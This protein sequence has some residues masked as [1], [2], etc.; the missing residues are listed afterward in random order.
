MVMCF[1]SYVMF[2]S[3]LAQLSVGMFFPSMSTF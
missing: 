1:V 3:T 2:T